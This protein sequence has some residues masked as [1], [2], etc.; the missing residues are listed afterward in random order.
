MPY[1]PEHID[2]AR[3]GLS[4]ADLLQLVNQP[5]HDADDIELLK[6]AGFTVIPASRADASVLPAA[7]RTPRH[8]VVVIDDTPGL[9]INPVLWQEL[10]GAEDEAAEAAAALR[11]LG[12]HVPVPFWLVFLPPTPRAVLLADLDDGGEPSEI[13]LLP[14]VDQIDQWA[15]VDPQLVADAAASSLVLTMGSMTHPLTYKRGSRRR[16]LVARPLR[17]IR[18][19]LEAYPAL[20]SEPLGGDWRDLSEWKQCAGPDAVPF[21]EVLDLPREFREPVIQETNTAT[22]LDTTTGLVEAGWFTAHDLDEQVDRAALSFHG[23][24]TRGA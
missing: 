23:Y 19:W 22:C 15:D 2:P 7:Q 16:D 21:W 4:T 10:K 8:G 24:R 12:P 18:E 6:A 11:K 13:L 9:R 14:E 20:V 1:W 17:T 5:H 3:V